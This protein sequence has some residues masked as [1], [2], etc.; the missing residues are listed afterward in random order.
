MQWI[1]TENLFKKSNLFISNDSKIS[2]IQKHLRISILKVIFCRNPDVH[3]PLLI[4]HN[5]TLQITR[6]KVDKKE[7]EEKK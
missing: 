2:L 1:K 5:S 3:H 6:L 4:S 7:E